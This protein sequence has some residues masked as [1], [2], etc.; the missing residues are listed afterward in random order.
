M[1]STST[2]PRTIASNG[3]GND[4]RGTHLDD[5]PIDWEQVEADDM[6]LTVV[7]L[8]DLR[9]F[10]AKLDAEMPTMRRDFA[11]MANDGIVF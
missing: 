5:T 6:G 10:E 2:L 9:A 7:E 11:E 3:R 4:P 1:Y 8:R